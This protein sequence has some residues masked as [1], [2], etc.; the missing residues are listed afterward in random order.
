MEQVCFQCAFWAV[1]SLFMLWYGIRESGIHSPV[2]LL[3]PPRVMPVKCTL[4]LGLKVL[5][6]ISEN[7]L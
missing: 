1:G 5:S 7:V 6:R 3:F 4:M 2:K